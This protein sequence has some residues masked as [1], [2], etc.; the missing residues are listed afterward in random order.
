MLWALVRKPEVKGH[1][2]DLVIG[3]MILVN[4]FAKK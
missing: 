2:E 1:F 3:G 4:L